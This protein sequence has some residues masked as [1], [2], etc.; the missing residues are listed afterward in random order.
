MGSRTP[1]GRRCRSGR[2]SPPEFHWLGPS[3]GAR[4]PLGRQTAGEHGG[5]STRRPPHASRVEWGPFG[6]AKRPR[7]V[8]VPTWSVDIVGNVPRRTLPSGETGAGRPQKRGCFEGTPSRRGYRGGQGATCSRTAKLGS[9]TSCATRRPNPATPA[10]GHLVDSGGPPPV[11]SAGGSATMRRPPRARRR[12][13]HSAVAAGGPKDRAVT[14]SNR[15]SRSPVLARCSARPSATSHRSLIRSSVTASRRK[16]HRR[17]E[18]SRSTSLALGHCSPRISPGTPPPDPR[19]QS[20]RAGSPRSVLHA[21]TNPRVCA[22][23]SSMGPGP[24]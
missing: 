24:R 16:R 19:S 3:T 2:S 14:R 4:A 22:R 15:P 6:S 11:A 21:E 12:A 20:S 10:A 1:G 5:H 7:W 8:P 13:A 18:A 17:A 23:W 9:V